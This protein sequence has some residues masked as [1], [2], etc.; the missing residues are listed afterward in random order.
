MKKMIVLLLAA[1]MVLCLCAC[2]EVVHSD[3][4][5]LIAVTP[6]V[7]SAPEEAV[8]PAAEAENTPADDA[9]SQTAPVM[10][11]IT[12]DDQYESYGYTHFLCEADTVYHFQAENSDG[13]TWLVYVLDE[14]FSD[15][16]R[17][18]SQANTEALSGDGEV[19]VKA[20]Q[21]VYVYCPV[22]SWTGIES[23]E[24]CRLAYWHD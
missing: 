10:T 17:Y 16:E 11:Y 20:G 2:G 8:L 23:P 13:L 3:E 5:E 22:N 12:P 21:V 7:S 19:S 18:I 1:A 9:D 6:S 14:E 15:S 24:G 4:G